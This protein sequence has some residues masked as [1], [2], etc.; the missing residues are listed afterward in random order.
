[1]AKSGAIS[2]TML[3]PTI[4]LFD[5]REAAG[6]A[7][8]A[9][10]KYGYTENE[11]TVAM[12]DE[13]RNRHFPPAEPEIEDKTLEGL[14][15]G[16]VIGGGVGALVGAGMREEKAKRYA[17]EIDQGKILIA[18][19]PHSNAEATRIESEWLDRGGKE[20]ICQ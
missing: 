17:D 15:A 1:M 13:T 7:Y 5:D 20:V 14:G 19:T 6:R 2:K 10:F 8:Q 9:L 12:S 4:G 18:V 3:D 16:V 11:I